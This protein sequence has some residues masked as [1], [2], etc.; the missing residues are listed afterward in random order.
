[1]R[2]ASFDDDPGGS[3]RWFARRRRD[4]ALDAL[5]S[6][7]CGVVVC[8]SAG[9]ITSATDVA[10]RLLGEAPSALQGQLLSNWLVGDGILLPTQTGPHW[11]MLRGPRG[12]VWSA[13][14]VHAGTW[15][16]T[17]GLGVYLIQP[18]APPVVGRSS[19]TARPARRTDPLTG[20]NDRS[21]FQDDL[22]SAM[23]G[24]RAS[25]VALALMFLDLDDFKRINDSL[26]HA[27]GDALLR[28][29]ADTL[30]LALGEGRAH[31]SRIGGDEFTV[32]V[33]GIGCA[34]DAALVAQRVLDAFEPTFR[35]G[36]TELQVSTSI[37]IALY[38][39]GHDDPDRLLRET[40]MAMYR[41]KQRG[42]GTY[43]F[44]SPEMG[45]QAAARV[46]LESGLRGALERDEFVLHY[47]PK[48]SL[49][50]GRVVGVEALL[51]W[52]RPGRGLIPPDRFV[53][54]LESTRLILTV[55]AWV[56]RTAC[57]DLVSWDRLGL[58]PLVMAVN[59]SPRQLAQPFL[60]RMVDDT[61]REH[62]LDPGRLELELT[63]SLLLEERTGTTDVLDAFARMGVRVAIDD[64]G[65]GH[66]SLSR[67]KR[68][69]VDTL[70]IDRS[71]VAELPHDREDLAIASAI[72]AMGRS[73]QMRV[74]AE[75]VETPAQARCLARLGCHEAQGWLVGRPMPAAELVAWL[76]DRDRPRRDGWDGDTEPM[77][78]MSL[79]TLGTHDL[80]I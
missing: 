16:G 27:A 35:L 15:N 63:E 53:P 25:G 55:G 57:A 29:V 9:R 42:R 21:A 2:S 40:D 34:E 65:T 48:V 56:L 71:F 51:R 3:R 26:G 45:A 20:L 64:F 36:R 10:A 78:L 32:I 61:V 39:G 80:E 38:D 68:L 6:S 13:L 77:T 54:V 24:A 12:K 17:E 7:D 73:L 4:D 72:V 59:L 49:E 41:S 79:E 11:R 33:P 1:M 74:V 66:S 46:E 67:L 5:A 8:D 75:G 60:A 14:L 43:S 52:R 76:Q 47:Q 18:G 31:V 37:G 44:F 62:G 58:P 23:A 50:T 28:H 70:K 22:A 19:E 30:C 69:D